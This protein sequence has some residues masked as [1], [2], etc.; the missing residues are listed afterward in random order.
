[1]IDD[2]G[3]SF[4]IGNCIRAEMDGLYRRIAGYKRQI[5]SYE[6]SKQ[7]KTEGKY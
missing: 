5:V 2:A 7:K 6:Q 1:L 4:K 3:D